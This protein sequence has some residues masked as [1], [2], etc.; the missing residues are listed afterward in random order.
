[1]AMAPHATFETFSRPN[2]PYLDGEGPFQL[3]DK[4]ESPAPVAAGNGAKG[5]KSERSTNKVNGRGKQVVI[6]PKVPFSLEGLKR[7]QENCIKHGAN[8]AF[9][10]FV[11]FSPHRPSGTT[12]GAF[13]RFART[14]YAAVTGVTLEDHGGLV[15]PI[16]Q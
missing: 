4:N 8:D 11:Q 5:I 9:A 3:P 14:L 1:M 6:S 16:R 13:A 7:W 2:V 15:R 12:T 10:F